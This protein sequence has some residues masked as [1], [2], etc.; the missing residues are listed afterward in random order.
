MMQPPTSG[1]PP[2]DLRVL[3]EQKS[4]ALSMINSQFKMGMDQSQQMFDYQKS[5]ISFEA[6]R[7]VDMTKAALDAQKAQELMALEQAFAQ[8]KMAIEQAAMQQKMQIEQTASQLE[9]TAAQQR[10]Q[11]D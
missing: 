1:A 11:R 8:Q 2:I 7:Q 9:F 4:K 3:A 5:T 10:M 6:D